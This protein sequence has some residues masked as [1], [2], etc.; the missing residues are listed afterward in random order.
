MDV[1]EQSF[2]RWIIDEEESRMRYYEKCQNYYEGR[3]KI[4]APDKYLDLVRHHY[5]IRVN[6]CEPVVEAPVSRLSI[7][8]ISCDDQKTLDELNKIWKY[9]RMDA[10]T[11]KIHR[12]A[13]KKGDA[14]AQVWPHFPAGSTT[15]DR[16]EIKFLSPDIVLP[17][18]ASDDA[19]SL[20]MV[21]KQWVSLN[22]DGIPVAHKWLFYPDRIERYYYQLNRSATSLSIT[23]SDYARYSWMEDD[24]DGFLAVLE[25]PY[26]MIPIIHFRNKE[27]DSPF[28]SSELHNAMSIQDGINKLVVSLMR[29]ADFQAFKQRYVKGVEEEEIPVNP[30]TGR[31]ELRSNPGDVWRFSGTPAE[32]DV[33]ELSEGDPTGLLTSI[34]DLVNHLSVVTR[35]PKSMLEDGAGT[36]ASGFALAKIEAPLIAKCDEKQISFGNSYEDIN[37]LLITMMQYHGTL[38]KGEIPETCIDWAASTSE[39]AEEQ[40]ANAQ[41]KQIL[42]QNNVISARQWAVEEGYTDEEIN[43]MQKEMQKEAETETANLLGHD[44]A[45]GGQGGGG[46]AGTETE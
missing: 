17:I 37:K 36:A 46:A 4:L 33:G 34:N 44:F 45:N 2:M 35:T 32:V 41:R 18:Y 40:L 38:A 9:N 22:A 10:K 5:G 7:E 1:I 8:G 25:N 21:R 13:I 27:D 14:F 39:S 30:D 42:R 23:L 3:H 20:L 24:T 31:R 12:N 19:E 28:G 11:I 43:R 26:G 15:P 6:Y 16:Y 29:T